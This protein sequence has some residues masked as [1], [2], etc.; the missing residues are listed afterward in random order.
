MGNIKASTSLTF[1]MTYIVV[2][3]E[4]LEDEK[5]SN[6]LIKE[7]YIECRCCNYS[8]LYRE[9]FACSCEWVLLPGTNYPSRLV[10]CWIYF[11]WWLRLPK[12]ARLIPIWARKRTDSSRR[13]GRRVLSGGPRGVKVI[14]TDRLAHNLV[15]VKIL[16]TV[17]NPTKV[18][19][20]LNK[21]Q[22]RGIYL[23]T[24]IYGTILEL[25]HLKKQQLKNIFTNAKI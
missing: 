5:L 13:W 25:Y 7:N 2:M 19:T 17:N 11:I 6:E 16:G 21:L 1:M 22:H 4:I 23:N 20:K 8:S 14:H 15:I 9:L 18:T 10:Q 12:Y 24:S 3:A